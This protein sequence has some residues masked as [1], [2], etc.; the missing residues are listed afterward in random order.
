MPGFFDSAASMLIFLRS[1]VAGITDLAARTCWLCQSKIAHNNPAIKWMVQYP[2]IAQ[3]E[4][5]AELD[6][7]VIS[8]LSHPMASASCPL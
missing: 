3:C 7:A 8:K 6:D 5:V 4:R 1:Y 2:N